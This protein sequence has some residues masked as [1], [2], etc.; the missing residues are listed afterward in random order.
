METEEQH[1]IFG[2]SFYRRIG[3]VACLLLLQKV[4]LLQVFAHRLGEGL[5]QKEAY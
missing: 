4:Y 1:I 3:D 2:T 5:K